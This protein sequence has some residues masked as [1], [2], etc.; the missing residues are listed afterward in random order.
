M[1][2]LCDTPDEA[3]ADIA[4]GSTGPIGGFGMA[5]P[6]ATV[7]QCASTYAWTMASML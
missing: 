2:L 5:V 6:R 4:D 1:T 3:V 7:T